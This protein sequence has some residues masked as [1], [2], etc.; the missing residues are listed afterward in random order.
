MREFKRLL[1]TCIYALL[2]KACQR[3]G[4]GHTLRPTKHTSVL[5]FHRVLSVS[6]GKARSRAILVFFGLDPAPPS[7]WHARL[8]SGA[9]ALD[10][11]RA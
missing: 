5:I 4:A 7:F 1:V 9:A 2:D 3:L 8:P 6:D 10:V 11:L